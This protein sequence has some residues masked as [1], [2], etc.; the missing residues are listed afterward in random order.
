MVHTNGMKAGVGQETNNIM[1]MERGPASSNGTR[2]SWNLVRRS[3]AE[4][5]QPAQSLAYSSSNT[6]TSR[7]FFL[8]SACVPK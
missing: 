5:V 7:S 8:L 6:R 1:I 4:G 3:D 2:T